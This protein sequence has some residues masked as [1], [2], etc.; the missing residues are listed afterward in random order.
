MCVY[1]FMYKPYFYQSLL[2]CTAVYN[3][4]ISLFRDEKTIFSSKRKGKKVDQKTNNHTQLTCNS[5]L[6]IITKIK[7]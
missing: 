4:N 2:I 7:D 1:V 3:I 6:M 5:A